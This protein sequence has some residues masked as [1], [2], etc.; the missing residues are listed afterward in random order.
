MK[1]DKFSKLLKLIGNTPLYQLESPNPLV[2]IFAKL[3]MVNPTASIKD[4]IASYIIMKAIQSDLINSK[5]H[6]FEG[7]SGNTGA[8]V[9]MVCATLGLPCTL[10]VPDKASDEKISLI[11]SYGANVEIINSQ[12]SPID[13]A[14]EA[15]NAAKNHGNAYC[16]DQYNNPLNLETHFYTTGREI[17]EQTDGRVD[18]FVSSASTGG[19]ICG[20]SKYLKQKNKNIRTVLADPIGSIYK[21]YFDK[22]PNYLKYAKPYLTEGA[23]KH[24]LVDVIDFKWIDKVISYTDDEAFQTAI[25]VAKIEGI[26]IGG[27]SGGNVMVARTIAKQLKKPTNIVTIFHDTGLKYLS[28]FY[29]PIWLSHHCS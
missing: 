12:S 13:Y 16:M 23:G 20:V 22:D 25:D 8:S 19:T 5:T 29:N 7:S 17:W 15:R 6:I 9:A 10:F 11:K 14:L 27:S 21:P 28:K 4:R 3:E 24:H 1:M 26:S 2:K 18:L